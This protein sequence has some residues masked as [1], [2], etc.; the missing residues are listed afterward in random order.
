MQHVVLLAD[1][2]TDGDRLASLVHDLQLAATAE[3]QLSLGTIV[4]RAAVAVVRIIG[5]PQTLFI[6]QHPLASCLAVAA[7]LERY[8]LRIRKFLFVVGMIFSADARD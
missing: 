2:D 7:V 1:I 6:D 4:L 3:E 8:L 5:R